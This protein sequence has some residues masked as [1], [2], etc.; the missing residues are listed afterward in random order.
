[1]YSSGHLAREPGGS[2]SNGDSDGGV[3]EA[4][5]WFFPGVGGRECGDDHHDCCGDSCRHDVLVAADD[6]ED[7]R[8]QAEQY[9]QPEWVERNIRR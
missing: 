2:E 4:K 7:E 9:R 1:V 8:S 6:H 3:D 5:D